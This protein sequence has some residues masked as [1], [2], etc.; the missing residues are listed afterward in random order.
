MSTTLTVSQDLRTQNCISCGV[1][2]AFPE[3]LDNRLRQTHAAFY[4]PSGHSQ[5]YLGK[6]EAEKLREQLVEKERLLTVARCA[7]VN[8]RN[9]RQRI[10]RQHKRICKR[11]HNGVCP[12][13]NRTF[14]NLARH[15][16][17]KHPEA[18]KA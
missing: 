6:T 18:V 11:V 14:A 17:T 12:C 1:L 4:C 10:E 8:E 9:A 16:A 2:F 15:M 5:V 7:E 3:E 13:C